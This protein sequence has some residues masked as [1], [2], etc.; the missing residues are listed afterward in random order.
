LI[1]AGFRLSHD[2]PEKDSIQENLIRPV[3]DSSE[4]GI[5]ID[6]NDPVTVHAGIC[7]TLQPFNIFRSAVAAEQWAVS[8]NSRIVIDITVLFSC[9]CR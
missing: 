8:I 4:I 1:L 2:L 7:R 5:V 6:R 3:P 9:R